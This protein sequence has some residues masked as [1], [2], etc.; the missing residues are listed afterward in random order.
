MFKCRQLMLL[1]HLFIFLPGVVLAQS[2]LTHDDPDIVEVMKRHH[3][4][5]GTVIIA[6]EE[7][8]IACIYNKKRANTRL[9]PASTFKIANSIIAIEEGVIKDQYEIIKW[10]GTKRFF[11][12]WNRDQNLKTAFLNSCVWF[13]QEIAKSIG[14]SKYLQYLKRFDYGNHLTGKQVT[15][16]WLEG[17]GDLQITPLEQVAFL[18]KLYHRKLAIS[19]RTYDI[20]EDIMLEDKNANYKIYSKE[21]SATQGGRGHVW[22]IAYITAKGHTWFVVTNIPV[23]TKK[24][25]S[26]RR[27]VTMEVLKRKGIV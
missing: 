1:L 23:N 9:S 10:D 13:Y 5:Q 18:Y 12:F 24:D 20:L 14:N 8:N 19:A 11:D 16:F 15:T 7:G 25:F 26:K 22:Y 27:T 2:E 3:A 4:V 6:N 21:A 17:K